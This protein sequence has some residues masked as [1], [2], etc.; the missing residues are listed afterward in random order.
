[1]VV[2]WVTI[3]NVFVWDGGFVG[4]RIAQLATIA[5]GNAEHVFDQ[6]VGSDG[7]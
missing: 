3:V 6:Y 5:I 4:Q 7:T 1:M 2:Q